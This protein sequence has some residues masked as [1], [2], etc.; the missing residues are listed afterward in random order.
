[1]L[2]K[3]FIYASIYALVPQIPKAPK[4]SLDI[5]FIFTSLKNITL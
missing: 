3:Y 1:M 5:A 2:D 4:T